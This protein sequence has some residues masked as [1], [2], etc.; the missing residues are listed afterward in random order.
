M[1]VEMIDLELYELHRCTLHV[2]EQFEIYN[3]FFFGLERESIT[4][5]PY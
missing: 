5:L 4:M 3:V 1:A 2:A